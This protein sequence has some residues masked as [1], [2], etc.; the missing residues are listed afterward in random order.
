MPA[1]PALIANGVRPAKRLRLVELRDAE[2]EAEQREQAPERR[3]HDDRPVPERLIR[4]QRRDVEPMR[5]RRDPR[6]RARLRRRDEPNFAAYSARRRPRCPRRRRRRTC[7]AACRGRA[8]ASIDRAARPCARA[9]RALAGA[10]TNFA[11]TPRA[12]ST[13]ISSS[14]SPVSA[15]TVAA[16]YG[17]ANRYA[18]RSSTVVNATRPKPL[19]ACAAAS[20]GVKR[21]RRDVE[22]GQPLE[23]RLR[24]QRR[25][26]ADVDHG[27]AGDEPEHEQHAQ[28]DAEVAV[29]ED[30]GAAHA[31]RVYSPIRSGGRGERRGRGIESALAFAR[32][33][34]AAAEEPM[35]VER[36]QR[37]RGAHA[38]ASNATRRALTTMRSTRLRGRPSSATS[39]RRRG[40][41]ND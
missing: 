34:H 30:Q 17:L 18:G 16:P 40:S 21:T 7:R 29:G 31:W 38:R 26:S 14:A 20:A 10:P 9:R 39:R 1:H 24:A 22:R 41:P 6:E 19:A 5:N 35:W 33:A 8:A 36:P 23:T 2:H 37:S 15:N 32:T 25:H 12:V 4:A 11:A 13:S 3:G 27:D 28:R